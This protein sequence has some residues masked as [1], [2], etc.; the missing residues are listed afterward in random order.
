M[1]A[2]QATLY[3]NGFFSLDRAQ[4]FANT[5]NMAFYDTEAEQEEV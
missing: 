1:K 2:V 5:Y 3:V 4:S